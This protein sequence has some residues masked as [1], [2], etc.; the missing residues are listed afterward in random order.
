MAWATSPAVTSRASGWRT[1]SAAA[2]ASGSADC[3]SS[4]PTHG[5]SAAGQ[6][7]VDAD[8]LGDVIGRHRQLRPATAALLAV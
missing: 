2:V 5:V 8:A 1:L 4:L 3:S 6:H 7:R